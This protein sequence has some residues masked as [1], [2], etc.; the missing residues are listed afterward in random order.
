ME[1]NLVNWFEIPVTDMTRA[2]KFY[3][4][5]FGQELSEAN[6]PG[7]EMAMFP[8][9]QGAPNTAGCLIKSEFL[10]P[11]PNA[12]A[13]YFMCNDVAETAKKIEEN[14]GKIITPKYSLGDWGFAGHFLDSEGNR[15][16]LHSVK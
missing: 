4:S 1:M 11:S 10:Q 2:R 13:V 15:M 12:T 7:I 9:I 3:S 14:G 6:M 16:G 5:V 8:W